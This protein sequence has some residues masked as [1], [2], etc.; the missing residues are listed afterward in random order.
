MKAEE[1]GKKELAAMIDYTEL[2]M[3]AT[4]NDM[5]KL[6]LEAEKYGF[7]AVAIHPVNVPLV[8]SLLKDT[9]VKVATGIAFHTGAYPTEVKVFE[10]RDAIEKGASE[11]DLVMNIGALKAKRYDLVR[12]DI[13]AVKN[14]EG[15]LVTKVILE[16]CLLTDEEKRKACEIA[17]EA[18]VD[19]VKTSTG[20][21]EKGATVEDVKLIK[22]TVGD[23]VGVKAAGGIRSV[24]DALSMIEAGASRIGTSSGVQIV[25]GLGERK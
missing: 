13:R 19:F 11:I 18:G 12:E 8:A 3:D 1:I 14:T 10:T 25:E 22:E 23:K 2:R 9:D 15:K 21:R 7:A 17:K 5:K 16:T 6:C 4:Y 20:F 24:D